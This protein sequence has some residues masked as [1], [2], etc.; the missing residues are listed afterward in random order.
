MT[1]RRDD[2][3]SINS[4]SI[5][6]KIAIG[7][8]MYSPFSNL[9]KMIYRGLGMKVGKNVYFGPRSIIVSNNYKKIKI[10]D[11]VNIAVGVVI[12]A[13]KMII[14][15]NTHVGYETLI[16]GKVVKIG[17]NCNIN[18]RTFIESFYAPVY[19]NNNVVI[20]A[21]AI[22]SSHDGSSMNVWG[23]DM[24]A[25]PVVLKNNCFIGNKAII[26]PGITIHEKVIVGAGSVVTK[27]VDKNTVVVGVPAKKLKVIKNMKK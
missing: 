26:M 4:M 10:K 1:L 23:K 20:A 18:N 19:I 17:K 16:T 21:S 13:E 9:K 15:K 22:I 14:G 12:N 8:A 5:M 27:D 3:N 6:K 24:K 7:I 25:K 11:N 2:T